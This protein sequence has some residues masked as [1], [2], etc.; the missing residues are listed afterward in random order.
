[1]AAS[2]CLCGICHACY[3]HQRRM[4]KKPEALPPYVPHVLRTGGVGIGGSIACNVLSSACCPTSIPARIAG[5]LAT[6][7]CTLCYEQYY[8]IPRYKYT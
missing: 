1:M 3:T 4:A 5:H 2:A 7:A 6:C 8:A